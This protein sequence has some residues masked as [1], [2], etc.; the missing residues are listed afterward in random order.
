MS[1]PEPR[2]V[3]SEQRRTFRRPVLYRLDVT[4]AK[5]RPVGYLVDISPGGMRVRCAPGVSVA[6]V[7]RLRIVFPHW[8][9]LNEPLMLKGRF[10]WCKP[11]EE[12]RTEGGF[13][14]D[15]LSPEKKE[16][17][18]AVIEKI[19]DAAIEDDDA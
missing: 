1:R 6:E 17:L 12:G 2:P 18:E 10:A 11:F 13:V 8:M 14:F 5:N 19:A 9:E 7:D 16:V 4:D 3:A 15:R